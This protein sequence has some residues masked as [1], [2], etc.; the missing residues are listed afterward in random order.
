MPARAM[1]IV[2]GGTSTRF[3]SD[4]LLAEVSGAPLIGHTLRAVSAVVDTVVV[5]VRPQLAAKVTEIDRR[6]IVALAGE[7]RT[8]SEWS[9]LSALGEAHDLIGIH[10]AARPAV[11]PE[12]VET[13]FAA[14][15]VC[16][17][18]VPMIEPAGLIVD[19]SGLE[20]MTAIRRAQTPQ[21]FHGPSLL[22]AYSRAIENRFE[23]HDTVEVVERFGRVT[24][25]A[26][27]GQES[28]MKVTYPADLE[29]V[30]RHL[31]SRARNAAR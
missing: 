25:A 8:R 17:G 20:P 5:V 2:G 22:E 27:P 4:K 26:V 6:A 3:G 12:L 13:I 9:G 1:I 10:D 7:T 29:I 19:R 21:V 24:I 30:R 23:G 18:A 28:N 31:S 15:A 14:A 11:D 16:G